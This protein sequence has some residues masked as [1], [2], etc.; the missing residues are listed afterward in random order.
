MTE[1]LRKNI[2]HLATLA[3]IELASDEADRLTHDIAQIVA[4][5]SDIQKITGNAEI[6]KKV[7]AHHTVMREDTPSHEPG[8]FTE[9]L[10]TLA[11]RRKGRYIEVK[12]IIGDKS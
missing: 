4:Y 11:P 2:D 7:G 3:R 5:V 12:K 9:A 10:L 6:K 8:E 1:I